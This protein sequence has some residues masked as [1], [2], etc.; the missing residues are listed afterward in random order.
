MR[1][2]NI[3]FKNIN[4]LEGESRINFEQPPFS[5]TGVFA[6]TGPN[7]SG[8]SSILDAITL[9]LYGET[10]RFD[11]PAGFVMTKHATECFSEVEF[12]LSGEKY[13]SGW[14]VQRTDTDA[15]D[16]TVSLQM[17]L[18]RLNDGAVL[19]ETV[20]D[21]CARITEITGMNFRNFTRS[22]L[23]AQG[24]FA[25]FLNA[26][27]TERMDIL[28]K[29]IST[30]IYAEYRKEITDKADQAQKIIDQ[31]KKSL[32]SIPLMSPEKLEACEQDLMDFRQQYADCQH[33]Q[34]ALQQQ[35]YWLL[36]ISKL[37]GRVI[38]QE[39]HIYELKAQAEQSR[40]Q[41]NQIAASENALLF[42]DEVA[43]INE[44]H[45]AIQQGKTALADLQGELKQLKNQLGTDADSTYS[46]ENATNKSFSDQLQAI[47]VLRTQ[48]NQLSSGRQSETVL[49]QSL[50]TQI[51]EKESALA[52]VTTW[53]D[54]HTA[55]E[56]LIE[57]FP[58]T[59]RLKKL[60]EELIVLE[61]KQKNCSKQAKTTNAS[62]TNNTSALDREYKKTIELKEQLE[63]TEIDFASLAP[64]KTAD[65]IDALKLE[66]QER[67]K[68]FQELNNL[69]QAHQRLSK[70]GHGLFSIF[71]RKEE[72]E[73]PDADTLSLELEKVKQE[74]KREENIKRALDASAVN[75]ALVRRMA[76]DRV[77]LVDGKPCPLCG[78]LQHPYVGRPP[79]VT[80]YQ[81]AL[82]DQQLKLKTLTAKADALGLQ[83]K[84][85][86]KTSEKNSATQTQIQQIRSQWLG[87]CNRLNTVSP[88]L[89]I[90]NLR[91]MEQLLKTE[92]GELQNI[93]TL[94]TK[95]R[96]KQAAIEKLKVSIATNADTITKLEANSGQLDSAWQERSQE[97][98][99]I[100]TALAECRQQE[101]QL[102]EKMLE[103]LTPLGE[104]MPAKG[105]EDALYDRLN[106][107]RQ[108][109]HGY[110]F[111][112]KSLTEEM[113]ALKAKQ[114]ACQSEI[115]FC[116]EQLEIY[117]RQLQ[118][119]ESVGLHLALIEKQKLIADK[120]QQLSRQ[121]SEVV[122]LQQA[123]QQKLQGTQFTSLKELTDI[124][125]LSQHQAELEQ[126]KAGLEKLILDKTA[127][128]EKNNLQLQT[129]LASVETSLSHE[130]IIA[131]LKISAEKLDIAT[132]EVQ[133]MEGL[134][135][136]QKQL[137][138]HYDAVLQQLEQQR[139]LSQ[140]YFA[141][142]AQMNA[143]SGIEF[144]RRVQQRIADQ[145]LAQTNAVLEKISG[146]YYI[147][148]VPSEQG[149]ALEIEDTY[150][151][152]V[153]RLPKSLS[154]GESFVV[155]LALALGL[156]EL[157]NN[158][159]SVD[160]LFID[161]GFGNLD[162]ETLYS[163][164]STLESLHTHHGKTVG[165]ISHVEAVQKRFKAQL[166]VVKKPN[167]MGMLKKAS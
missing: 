19:A 69:A 3:H 91:L 132:M 55:D 98:V 30:D 160:S 103:Q 74:I 25:A 79:V 35:Q 112:H 34:S 86:Q 142:E 166:Q 15:A 9:G 83:I 29:I 128:L 134:L 82:K 80:D 40:Q 165:V 130:D 10:F 139:E 20:H 97:Q 161:E 44:S 63:A 54:E 59:G 155:S 115:T 126:R 88:D 146:R 84:T 125:E 17:Q 140:P 21:V 76:A 119:E 50:G 114:A 2:L 143:E 81:Q 153:R 72:P 111:R 138:Q 167:G 42:K 8:K 27:D 68:D 106:V 95:Y 148:K 46:A 123:L 26:L 66:Q 36:E 121:E 43:A 47:S 14:Y 62:L 89:A 133:H 38:E 41:L 118:T 33:Q 56:S 85:A 120:E 70:N 105:K 137:Q 18:M 152:N 92:I 48:I 77:H 131:Q 24:D 6:I 60:R 78:A 116:N 135:R 23:L 32:A 31:L 107:R 75:A 163:V 22:I 65:D 150:Q 13:K 154:G 53:L 164:I 1:I 99:E 162:A 141:E 129:Y 37:Q 124:L 51:S 71:S 90:D 39:K 64:G 61:A 101:K 102:S 73:L 156:S 110:A 122:I 5:D 4:S 93:V 7:G 157:A 52:S 12:S 109:Y 100:D 104:K 58:E 149:L 67:V 87:L 49:W 113:D 147:R 117:S 144:R 45:Q 28:E 151:A 145:L 96:S 158:G 136:E 159:K 94:A 11:R 57:N 108:E 127:E 16:Q